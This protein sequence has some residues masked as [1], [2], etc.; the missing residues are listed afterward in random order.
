MLVEKNEQKAR[1]IKNIEIKRNLTLITAKIKI[2]K[3]IELNEIIF[4]N[5]L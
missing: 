1:I 5:I 3:A 2:A 4:K